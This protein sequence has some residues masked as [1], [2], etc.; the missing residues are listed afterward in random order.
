VGLSGLQAKARAGSSE[1]GLFLA[2]R[3]WFFC[4]YG[5]NAGKKERS[6]ITGARFSTLGK[7][8]RPCEDGPAK[9][10]AL[11]TQA[12]PTGQFAFM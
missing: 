3:A 1:Q 12:T 5:L 4:Y 6:Q 9:A 11:P 2:E 8:A 10:F 7:I